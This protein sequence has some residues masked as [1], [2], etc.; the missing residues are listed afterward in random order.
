MKKT[1]WLLDKLA[2]KRVQQQ[3]KQHL[4]EL[5]SAVTRA[6]Q[7]RANDLLRNLAQ[8][9]GPHVLLGETEWGQ[10]VQLPLS[11]VTAAHSIF[12]GGSGAGK[13][14]AILLLLDA[15]LAAQTPELSFAILDPKTET[16][17]NTQYLLARSLEQ[18]PPPQAEALQQRIVIID[19]AASD[20]VTSYNIAQPWGGSD[21]D[22]F[23]TSRVETMTEVLA[24]GEG[25]SLRGNII[26]KYLLK[27]LAECEVPF[28]YIERVLSDDALRRNLLTRVHSEDVREYFQQRFSSESKATLAALQARLSSALLSTESLRL[29][30]SGMSAPD[31]RRYQDEGKI[32]LINC[33]GANISRPTAR[34]LQALLLS[35]IRQSVY[36]RQTHTPYIFFMDEA[37]AALRTKQLRE[38]ADEL[39]RL[40]RSFGSYFC[41]ITQNLTAGA[42]DADLIEVIHTNIKWSLSLRSTPRDAAFLKA[43]LP[44]T[45]R[46][47]KLRLN[48]YAPQEYLTL[49]E[50]RAVQME[51]VAHLPDRVGWLWLKALSGEAIKIKTAPMHL[52]SGADFSTA[53]ERLRA[54]PTIGQRMARAD[55]LAALKKREAAWGVA[56]EAKA[57][58]QIEQL[59]RRYR[60]G[61]IL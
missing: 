58:N 11:F 20:P 49:V 48:P 19:L 23:T 52:P 46:R 36:A 7:E 34:V 3:T 27:L 39:L 30:L 53:V 40:A 15:I 28:G 10:A 26:V 45:G 8:Q 37:Q 22:F 42:G 59:K 13:S 21:L 29:S 32:L 47:P 17:L 5:T 33:G 44:V 61:Q 31:F 9:S 4:T 55:Y 43:A 50:E 38:N 35:D 25:L 14:R 56:P 12:S 18:L 16:F 41:L 54:N 24:P 1:L 57:T 6:T 60:K 51:S 2:G